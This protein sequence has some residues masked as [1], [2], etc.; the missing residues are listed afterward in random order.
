MSN[1]ARVGDR[2][3][4]EIRPGHDLSSANNLAI[5]NIFSTS[6]S[7]KRARAARRSLRCVPRSEVGAPDSPPSA[8]RCVRLTRYF[9][10]QQ[11]ANHPAATAGGLRRPPPRRAQ[12][13]DGRTR[14]RL[15]A[16]RRGAAGG[17]VGGVREISAVRTPSRRPAP[18]GAG[19]GRARDALPPRAARKPPRSRG[20]RNGDAGKSRTFSVSKRRAESGRGGGWGRAARALTHRARAGKSVSKKF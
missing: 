5:P 15:G 7:A 6:F 13:G 12:C 20:T 1:S 2:P 8:P 9:F 18:G 10:V 17:G 11:I 4:A 19:R 3:V 14:G 16:I